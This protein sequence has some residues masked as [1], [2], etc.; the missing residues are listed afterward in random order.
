MTSSEFNELRAKAEKG[1]RHAMLDLALAYSEGDGVEHSNE[2]FF[3]WVR[4]SAMAGEPE[5]AYELAYAYKRGTGVS[6]DGERF[7]E[8]LEDADRL[9]FLRATFDL[10]NLYKDG[11]GVPR[12][13][14][15]FFDLMKKA[16]QGGDPD[17]MLDLAFAFRD[18]I[19]TKRRNLAAYFS[20]LTKSAN[21][22]NPEAMFHL[23]FEFKN[24]KGSP[25]TNLKEFF[26]WLKKAAEQG[27][28]QGQEQPDALFHLAIAYQCG[29]GTK[30]S[31]INYFR[32]MKRAAEAGIPAASYHLAISYFKKNNPDRAN[33]SEWIKRALKAG[34][35][36]AFIASGLDDLCRET[37]VRNSELIGL[38]EDLNRLFDDVMKIK[39]DHIVKKQNVKDGVAHFTR[40]EALDSMLPAERLPE[41][42]TNRLRLYNFAYMN[43]PQ[44]GKRL[45]DKSISAD[46][47]LLP[48]FT[49]E[50]DVVNPLRWEDHESSVY[51]GSFTLKG[52]DLDI[53]RTAYGNDGQ[54]YCILTPLESFDQGALDEPDTLH[55][56]EIVNVSEAPL[57][58]S[59]FLPT[60]LYR[61]RYSDAEVR[62]TLN[63][64]KDGLNRIRTRRSKLNGSTKALDRTV[65]LIVSHILY[66]YKNQQYHTEREARLI[67]ELDISFKSLRP[68]QR[69]SPSK[70]FVESPDFLFKE[71][72]RII[73]GPR[74]QEQTVVELDLKY[75]LARHGLLNNTRVSRSALSEIYR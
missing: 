58:A 19:G 49:E 1:D 20:W 47:P 7:V 42:T 5:A 18:R 68:D 10:A 9:G 64:L 15:V 4:K 39:R 67:S 2:K 62:L 51:I 21:N 3:D 71:G 12:N 53:W 34:H 33:F 29:E 14:E 45:L 36:R 43:D 37:F 59:E 8:W 26:Y 46:S 23:A 44:E 50:E 65:R 63:E 52:E 13:E 60:T 61:I 30:S 17:A 35:P 24:R 54:G 70:V 41:R 40:F 73:I 6:P 75:R 22:E 25:K 72:S 66:L 74:V 28:A 69:R 32:W 31:P 48:F 11:D 27:K 16:A 38:N 55:G 56:G 57:N